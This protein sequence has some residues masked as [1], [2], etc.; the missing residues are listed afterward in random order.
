[1]PFWLD[2]PNKSFTQQ[3]IR[4]A[5]SLV[6]HQKIRSSEKYRM[7]NTHPKQNYVQT[8]YCVPLCSIRN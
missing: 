1:M 2:Y 3:N 8:I 5:N 6:E 7:F 4:I